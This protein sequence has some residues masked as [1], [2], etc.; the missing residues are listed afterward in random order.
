[1]DTCH[2]LQVEEFENEPFGRGSEHGTS[3]GSMGHSTKELSVNWP[4]RWQSV[5]AGW[6]QVNNL[7][8]EQPV[9]LFTII[10]ECAK[11]TSCYKQP[12]FYCTQ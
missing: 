3:S 2:Q 4:C 8:S 10:V 7:L 1:M 6:K 9:T 5:I 12:I 11:P